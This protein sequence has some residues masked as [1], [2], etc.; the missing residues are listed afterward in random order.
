MNKGLFSSLINTKSWQ[1]LLENIEKKGIVATYGMAEGFRSFLAAALAEKTKRPI[2][3]VTSNELQASKAVDDIGQFLEEEVALLPSQN[4]DFGRGAASHESTWRRLETLYHICEENI[5]VLCLSPETL[6]NK[7]VSKEAFKKGIIHLKSAEER[8]PE[9]LVD[10]LIKNGYERV[11]MVEGKGQCAVRGSIID[12]YPPNELNAIRIEFFDD[13]IDSIRSFD[14]LSQRSIEMLDEIKIAPTTEVVLHHIDGP[15]V[16]EKMRNSIQ[17]IKNNSVDKEDELP[18]L[19]EYDDFGEEEEL[20]SLFDIEHFSQGEEGYRKNHRFSSFEEPEKRLQ[21]QILEDADKIEQGYPFKK[22]QTW[23]QVIHEDVVNITS[24]FPK[25]IIMVNQPDKVK[26]R[27]EGHYLTFI[28]E[29]KTTLERFDAVPA[30]GDLL[31]DYSQILQSLKEH[32]VV[33]LSDFLRGMGQLEPKKVI[34]FESIGITSYNSNVKIL[35]EDGVKWKE[36]GYSIAILS[37]SEARGKRLKENLQQFNLPATYTKELN[38]NLIMGEVII[39]PM[40]YTNGFVWDEGKFVFITDGDI[41][42]TGFHK[43]KS[44]KT[45]GEKITSFTQLKENDFVVHENHGIGIY[46][47]VISLESEGVKKDYLYIQYY[48]NDKLYVPVDQMDRI[49][50]FIGGQG[51]T[52]KINRLSGGEWQKQK[53]K[54]KASIKEMAFDLSKLYAARQAV[55]GNAFGEDTPWQAAFEDNFPYELT[56]DQQQSV[57]EIKQDMES[58]INMD[59][60]LCGDVGYGKTEVAL[61]AAFKAVMDGKQVALLAPTTI[62]VQQHFN[63]IV[64]RLEGFPITCDFL[65]R[66]KKPKEQKEVLSKLKFGE[67]DF[68]VGTHRLLGKDVIFKDLGLLIIDEEQRF[69]VAHKEIIKNMKTKVDVLSMS[70]TPIPRTLHMSMIGIRDMSILETP[71][72][73]RFPVQTYVVEYNDI[74]MRDI[75]L[76]EIQR[77]GQVYFLYN[78]VQ[79]IERFYQRIKKLVPEARIGIAHGQMREHD[80]EDV[81]MDFYHGNYDVLLCT[82]IIESGLD[83]P[84]AN[85]LIVYDAD[86]FGLSQLYQLRGRVGRS[87]RQAYAYF[88]VRVD[89]ILTETAEKRLG[90]IREF[91]EFGS[92]F[93]IAMRDLEIRGAGNVLGPE[94]HGQLSTVGYDMY[95]KLIEEAMAELKGEED[96]TQEIDTQIELS[97]NAYLPN[98]YIEDKEQRMDIYKRIAMIRTLEDKRDVEDEIVD[99]FGDIPDPVENLLYIGYLKALARKLGINL[100]NKKKSAFVLRFDEKNPPDPLKL[101][102]ALGKLEDSNLVLMP[103]SPPTLQFTSNKMELED[104]LID[105]TVA[106]EGLLA[107][108]N[109]Q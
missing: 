101:V 103:T 92:G 2:I 87:N 56:Q 72:E 100:V 37:S 39:L 23:I 106:L 54:V 98:D 46:Q 20:P 8:A 64:K 81:M 68:M 74:Q 96:F 1:D 44:R 57:Q 76:R 93:R 94:Q 42:G 36:K 4:I 59:R 58:I 51:Q 84:T 102:G 43:R 38:H 82:T 29:F 80:L 62:L 65:S 97:I 49:Q 67:L 5:G 78:R 47:G 25:A 71:P 63:T 11:W 79:S 19:S 53:G 90:A 41:Y 61:R 33:T 45:S 89:K 77:G 22:I 75:I 21:G 52:P 109:E 7:L 35:A 86:R 14:M 83:I 13:E 26:E 28:E 34:P 108:M 107:K 88:T 24:W 105:C 48:G 70:A 91:T 9:E 60:L 27:I 55:P 18:P 3:Y 30:Q 85:T 73:E 31:W 69:G 15:L 16:A 50:K 6:M 40:A 12:V 95:V 104:Q 10:Q 66:F 32:T 99:R 17:Y